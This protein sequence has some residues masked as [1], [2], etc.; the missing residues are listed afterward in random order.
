M[1]LRKDHYLLISDATFSSVRESRADLLEFRKDVALNNA[2]AATLSCALAVVTVWKVSSEAHVYPKNHE[3][4]S[5]FISG[6]NQVSRKP[7]VTCLSTCVRRC[8]VVFVCHAD[9]D[10]STFVCVSEW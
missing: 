3:G 1:N 2:I 9:R 8:S 7:V 10:G 6:T 4:I 5:V